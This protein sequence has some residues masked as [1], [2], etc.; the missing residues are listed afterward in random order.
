MKLFDVTAYID[1]GWDRFT[2]THKVLASDRDRAAN[3][4]VIFWKQ[5]DD[6]NIVKIRN[7]Q[8]LSNFTEGII[9]ADTPGVLFNP[10]K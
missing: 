8:E 2:T 10:M 7:V 9:C 3:L 1:D 6:T 5:K 4:V